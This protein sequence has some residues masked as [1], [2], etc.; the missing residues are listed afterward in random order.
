MKR[1]ATFFL[2]CALGGSAHASQPA[3]GTF[4]AGQRCEAYLSFRKKTNPG[5]IQTESGREYRIR[6]VN[7]QDYQWLRIELPGSAEPL[8]WVAAECGSVRDLNLARA[9][10]REPHARPAGVCRTPGLQDSYVLA[11]TWQPGFCEHKLEPNKSRQKPE[12]R[13]MD[14]GELE[15]A[16][17]TLH[18]LWPN[19][20]ECGTNYGNCGSTDIQ[21]SEET[22]ALV[23]PWMPN[24]RFGNEFGNY[25]WKKHGTCQSDMDDDTYFRRAV[26][27]VRT[28]NDSEVGRYIRANIGGSVERQRL[29][30][31]LRRIHPDAPGSFS[32]LCSGDRL[33]EIRVQL[34]AQF[35]EG[36]GLAELI[37]PAPA[38]VRSVPR[39]E[40]R[41][42]RI[43]IERSGR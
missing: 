34:P 11:I 30:E 5:P 42:A 9:A 15:V 33:H 43:Q 29:Q 12:C 10:P 39:D 20:R 25:E 40:C 31:L 28:F 37:G 14:S 36:P 7:Q 21:L 24:F 16:N 8:R 3:T 18:G 27:A 26:A 1:L 32:F 6:E 19:K 13:A 35:R 2:L 41:Q 17:F 23:R 4:V 22:L 38:R